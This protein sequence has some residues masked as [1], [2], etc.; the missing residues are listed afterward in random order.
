M[1]KTYIV[2]IILVLIVLGIFFFS[3]KGEAPTL[4]NTNNVAVPILNAAGEKEITVTGQ[5]FSFIPNSITVNKGD[6]VR[7]D[8][9]N[10]DGFHNLIIDEFKVAT[11]TIK[12]GDEESVE[13]V[14]DKIGSFQ[15]YCSVGNHRAMGMWGTLIVK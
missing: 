2:I 11:K 7:I 15:Y 10:A 14:A 3:R 1:K 6:K 8:F 4:T 9:K 13:F 5:N 12:T